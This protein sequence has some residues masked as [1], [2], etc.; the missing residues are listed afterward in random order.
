MSTWDY[1]PLLFVT[2]VIGLITPANAQ[3]TDVWAVGDGEKIF[4]YTT[5]HFDRSENSI[6][7]GE[8]IQ[9]RGLR[10]EVLAFQVV[11]VADSNGASTVEI[12]VQPPVHEETGT[13]IGGGNTYGPGGGF[14]LFSQHYL[15]VDRPTEPNWFYGSEA[16][17]PEP[18]TGWIPDALIPA[19]ALQGRGGFPVD[20]PPTEEQVYRRQDSL[21][22][23][24]APPYQ[25]QGFWV[26]L[27]L[28]R[29]R[30][31]PAGTYEGSIIVRSAGEVVETLP[32][33]VT[34]ADAYL[35]DENHS[36]VWMFTSGVDDYF[37][38]LTEGQVDRMV[39]YTAHRHRIDAVGGFEPHGSAFD[40]TMMQNY[41]PYLTG[42]AFTAAEGYHGPGQG[43]GEN[44][45][46]IGMYGSDVLGDTRESVQRESDKWVRWFDE[47]APDVQYFRYLIDEPG[48]VQ[49]PFIRKRAGWIHENSG[50][51]S[52]LPVF[53]TREFTP[54]I[55]ASIDVWAGGQTIPLDALSDVRGQGDDHMFYNGFRP[56]Y[57]AV[58]LEGAAV[59]LRVDA[60]MKYLYGI[61][62]WFLWHS[63]HWQH[64]MQGP[65]G[66]LHQR[67]F[68]EPLTFISWGMS[69]GNGDGVF[70]YPGQMPHYPEQSRGLNRLLPS[71]RLKNIRRG[72]QDYEIMRLA[73]QEVGQERVREIIRDVVPRGFSEVEE[74]EEV[75][76][77]VCGDDYDRVRSLLI[78]SIT[79]P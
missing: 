7:D 23:I 33:E 53:T 28:P 78:D 14:A 40:S 73:A 67:V 55:D 61:D 44:L 54:E 47:H 46:P 17:A 45:F 37:P 12:D 70:L 77:S 13:V 66:H 36:N 4:R 75:Q 51:G 29:D 16:S 21:A 35:P 59:D 79:T 34:L 68:E 50:P 10:N 56:R 24:P 8:Q 26:D 58:I 63:T 6:W 43:E 48:E 64:N 38:D 27:Y 1:A 52:R 3:V 60:W 62:T 39:K 25:N 20:I 49:Y 42:E 57:G 2:L 9:I 32:L 22:V 30:S 74:N 11:V 19:D 69:F 71:I 41:L 5:D 72:Q 18:M 31:Y 65:K 15:K 76:W